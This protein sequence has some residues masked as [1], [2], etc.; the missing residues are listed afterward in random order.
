[1]GE[2]ASQVR[3][4]SSVGSGDGVGDRVDNVSSGNAS[5]AAGAGV[6]AGAEVSRT[7]RGPSTGLM[8]PLVLAAVVGVIA[9]FG[10]AIVGTLLTEPL[11]S[12]P[13]ESGP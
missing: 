8:W 10:V 6:V 13:I 11:A 7:R 3:G 2:E 12:A 9:S 1:M 5:A 4:K